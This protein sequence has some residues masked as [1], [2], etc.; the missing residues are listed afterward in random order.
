MIKHITKCCGAIGSALVSETF[1]RFSQ[2][3]TVVA[4]VERNVDDL[5]LRFQDLVGDDRGNRVIVGHH[6]VFPLFSM[7]Q[8]PLKICSPVGKTPLYPDM[9][10][11]KSQRPSI[12]FATWI[13]PY[14]YLAFAA[15]PLPRLVMPQLTVCMDE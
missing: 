9:T 12:R 11:L 8:R 1:S 2:R 5:F 7:T 6:Y 14:C 4:P 10:A 3:T 15:L 13:Q